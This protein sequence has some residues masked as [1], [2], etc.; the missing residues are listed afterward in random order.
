MNV[1]EMQEIVR[2]FRVNRERDFRILD[3]MRSRG[4]TQ[5]AATIVVDAAMFGI[6]CTEGD[7]RAQVEKEKTN[8]TASR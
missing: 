4:M 8:G 6:G 7:V 1:T 5:R 2:K 3:L